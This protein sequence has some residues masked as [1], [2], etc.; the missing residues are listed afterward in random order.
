MKTNKEYKDEESGEI[1]GGDELMYKG[2]APIYENQDFSTFIKV[3]N[4]ICD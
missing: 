1:Y 4:A 2:I 3:F